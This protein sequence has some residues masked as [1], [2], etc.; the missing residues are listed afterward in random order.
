[1]S[2][3]TTDPSMGSAPPA[4][5]GDPAGVASAADLSQVSRRAPF[6]RAITHPF[7]V[8]T[9][10]VAV[11]VVLRALGVAWGLPFR[12]HPDE[13]VIFEGAIDMAKRNSFEPQLFLRPDHVEIKLSYLAYVVYGAVQHSPVDVLAAADMTPFIVISRSIT[14]ALGAIT[15]GLAYVVG[16]RF[17]PAVGLV[18]AGL[19][20]LLP[21]YIVHAHYATPD[22]PLTLAVLVVAW[23]GMRYLERPNWPNLLLMSAAVSVSIGIKYPGAIGA[24]MIAIAVIVAAARSRRWGQILTR[25]VGSALGVVGF[26]FIISPVLF[27]NVYGVVDAIRTESR[28]THLG[29]D[30]LGWAGNLHYYVNT[31]VQ[32]GGYILALFAVVGVVWTIRRRA[33]AAIPLSVGAVYWVALSSV[34]LHW[35]RWALPMYITPLLFA[36]IGIV[37]TATFLWRRRARWTP[38]LRSTFVLLVA[39]S[40]TNLAT[41]AAVWT[42]RYVTNDSRV[43]AL[44]RFA[45]YALTERNTITEGYTP[46]RPDRSTRIFTH[47]RVED[48]V[49]KIDDD[50]RDRKEKRYV[51]IS[52]GM[53]GRFE[54]DPRYADEQ[55]FYRLLDEQ[56]PVVDTV[57]PGSFYEPSAIEVL[58]TWR[59]IGY[60]LTA[61]STQPPGPR[62]VLYEIPESAW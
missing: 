55:E 26:L 45:P 46:L 58:N 31:F 11:G 13:W 1:M 29:S 8:L 57:Q 23:G 6:A 43:E 17:S 15:I 50:V 37:M 49:L 22:V 19:F 10:I 38:W 30:G 53:Y 18:S 36:A 14:V 42:V 27:T 2:A 62:I 61:D 35:G 9:I 34:P 59:G 28:S 5:P 54:A 48:G 47:F 39:V 40:A 32:S 3:N 7:V 21:P 51:M 56:F 24:V 20:A 16:R 60:L 44:H 41:N 4:L 52:S 25:G 33:V 12:L